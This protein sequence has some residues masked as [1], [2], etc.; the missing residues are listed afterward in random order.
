[1]F[2][3]IKA[4]HHFVSSE[5]GDDHQN[6]IPAES[7]QEEDNKPKGLGFFQRY[8][9]CHDIIRDP[10]RYFNLNTLNSKEKDF[11]TNKAHLLEKREFL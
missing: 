7:T 5:G 2:S 10:K 4:H 8:R 11:D 6:S 9:V 3:G 1:M